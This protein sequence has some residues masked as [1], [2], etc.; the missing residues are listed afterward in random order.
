VTARPRLL[1][2][3][4]SPIVGDARVL[5]QVVH[6]QKDYDVTTCGYGNA[7]EGVIRHIRIPDDQ[8][9]NNLYPRF[10]ALRLFERVYWRTSAVAWCKSH[11]EPGDWDVILANDVETVPLALTLEP[12]H[13]VHADLHEYSPRLRTENPGWMRWISPYYRW[14]CRKHVSRA[15][16][17]STVG[18][19]LARQYLKEYGFEP[20]VVT[21]AAP[22]WDLPET[23]VATPLRMVHSG[24]GLQNR[25]LEIML[26]AV[27]IAKSKPTFDLYLT[28]N[29][30]A[31]IIKLRE[32]AAEI[33][34]V[35]VHDPVPYSE[36]IQTLNNYDVGLFVLPPVNFSYE[37]ALP[38]KIFDFIQAR[39]AIVVGPSPEM[40]AIVREYELGIV[41][42]DFSVQALAD[43]IDELTAE[44][45]TRFKKASASTAAVLDS[46]SQ[47][48]V[49]DRAIADLV[50]QRASA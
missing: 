22:Y 48:A 37:W 38:N 18:G 9:Q 26:E 41:A 23:A 39:L 32:R 19:G 12:A 5:K 45:V 28:A 31:Y 40:A 24:A 7:P 33:G 50:G 4:F 11:L 20:L 49:W 30:P 8:P 25:E 16:S 27:A 15:S 13:G 42:R 34:R 36:L 29:H 21:N 43:A 35:T 3:S 47:V 46:E 10:L 44:S 2:L 6:F 14:M 1:I 17:W